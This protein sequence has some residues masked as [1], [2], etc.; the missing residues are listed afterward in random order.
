MRLTPT[1]FDK[2]IPAHRWHARLRFIVDL[3]RIRKQTIV[4]ANGCFDVLHAGHVA[5]LRE[6]SMQGD[7]LLVGLNSDRTVARRKGEDRPV[8]RFQDRANVLAAI[9]CVDHVV[10]FDSDTPRDLIAFVRPD[11]YAIGEEYRGCS[12]G[13]E[14]AGRVHY[15]D[16]L[17]GLSTTRILATLPMR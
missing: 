17:P 6:A 7:V 2:I 16:R 12:P 3:C 9:A 15:I 1:P 4:L 13:S 10:G 11:V 14:F 8:H 5:L